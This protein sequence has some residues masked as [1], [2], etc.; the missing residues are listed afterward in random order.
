MLF[1]DVVLRRQKGYFWGWR[2][3]TPQ[4]KDLQDLVANLKYFL[5]LGRGH[6]STA[7]RTG[8]SSTTRGVLGRW[9]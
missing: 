8:R 9:A 3:M 1:R 6:S 2:S 5:Y 4:L 7:G